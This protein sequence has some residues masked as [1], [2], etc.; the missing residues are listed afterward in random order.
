MTN[1]GPCN[2]TVFIAGC[3]R[4]GTT[5]LRTIIDA[6]PDI[7]IP[8]ESLFIIDYFRYS[9]FIPK[10]ILQCF[11]FR[12]PQLRAWYN[13]SSFPIDNISRTITR[14]HKYTAKQYNAKLWGQKTPR[15]IRHIDLF[16]DY[17]PNIKWILIY[18]DPRAVVSS[19]LKSTRHTYSIDRAC[20]R[21]IRDNKPIAKL[22]KSQN[23]PQNIFILKYETL[24][25][26]FDNVI[27]EL[28]NFIGIAPLSPHEIF[29]KGRVKPFKNSNFEVNAV[30][31]SLIPQKDTINSWKNELTNRQ[32][33]AIEAKCS[34][35]MEILGYP[36]TGEKHAFRDKLKNLLEDYKNKAKD[37]LILLEYMKKW[38]YYLIHTVLRK[39]LFFLCHL[40]RTHS[41]H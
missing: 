38:P 40:F 22:L 1:S 4:S 6:H 35:M 2:R 11:F 18:R 26:D 16:E 9:Q 19:M 17:I 32:I 24:I 14:I 8:T 28:F 7:Y 39:T 15:F 41:S 29:E 27:K 21:W 13:G 10:P 5:Y 30:R 23:Q 3:G 25:N 34:N 12:E 37:F 31:G 20:I 33:G 36:L